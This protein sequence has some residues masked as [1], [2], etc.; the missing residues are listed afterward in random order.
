MSDTTTI[1][2]KNIDPEDIS[3]VLIKVEKSFGFKFGD[4]ELKDVK[5]FGELCDIITNKVQG[6]TADDCTTQQGFYKLRN[7]IAETQLIDRDS[8]TPNTELQELFR[9][10]NRRP[11]IKELQSK[12]GMPVDIL[13][14]KTWLGWTIFIGIIASPIMFFFKWQF[15]L[16]GLILFIAVGWAANKFFAKEFELKTVRQLT[17]KLARE[18]YKKSRCNPATVNKNEIAIKVKELFRADL[19]LDDTVLTRQATFV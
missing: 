15:A 17:E 16:G 11:R 4:T 13:D 6:D 12:L 9:R 8:I 10:D 18:N 19:D 3:D 5:T 2:L 14:I 1:Q 7:A